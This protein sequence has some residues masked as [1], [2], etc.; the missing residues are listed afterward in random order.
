MW[1]ESPIIS[2]LV[3]IGN[4]LSGH[5]EEMTGERIEK[6]HELRRW[7]KKIPVEKNRINSGDKPFSSNIP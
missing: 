5:F 2:T 1:H 3:V 7:S 4:I 6:Y